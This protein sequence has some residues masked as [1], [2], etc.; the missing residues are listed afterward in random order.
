[1]ARLS[2][3][4]CLCLAAILTAS[5]LF[6]VE[7]T[8]AQT[9]NVTTSCSIS[10]YSVLEGQPVTVYIQVYPAPSI[11]EVFNNLTVI[12]T[13]PMQGVYGNGLG[14]KVIYQLTQLGEQQ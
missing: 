11:G 9:E 10:I 7:H 6:I 14:P 12:I 4:F 5:S 2:K 8:A 13:S 3:C 1:M